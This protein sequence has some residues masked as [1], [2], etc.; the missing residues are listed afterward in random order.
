[1]RECERCGAKPGYLT[2]SKNYELFD[3]CANCAKNL[4][5]EC[6]AKGC[7]GHVPAESGMLADNPDEE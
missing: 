5:P 6:M 2:G 1:M 4:C 7:C 3:Y